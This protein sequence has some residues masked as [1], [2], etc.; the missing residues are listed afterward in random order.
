VIAAQQPSMANKSYGFLWWLN[1]DNMYKD[2]PRSIYLADGFGGNFIVV[3]NE[4]DLVVVARWLEPSK[5]D[6]FIKLVISS[7]EK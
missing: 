7:I 1:D 5:L 2:L 4:H 3:D 6:E